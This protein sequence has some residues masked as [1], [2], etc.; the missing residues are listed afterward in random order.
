MRYSPK[1]LGLNIP[2]LGSE[3]WGETEEQSLNIYLCEQPFLLLS[4]QGALKHASGPFLVLTPASL[5]TSSSLLFSESLQLLCLPVFML[6]DHVL[7]GVPEL[8][9]LNHGHFSLP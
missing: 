2:R 8:L 5:W 4:Y 3:C 7:P 6:C 9:H 1:D